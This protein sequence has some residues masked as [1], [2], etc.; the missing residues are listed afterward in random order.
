MHTTQAFNV[1]SECSDFNGLQ[2]SEMK[3]YRKWR[4]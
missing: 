1:Q 2:N 4:C 3:R